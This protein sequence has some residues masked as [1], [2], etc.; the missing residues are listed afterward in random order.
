MSRTTAQLRIG[1]TVATIAIPFGTI[2]AAP[3]ATGGWTIP[4]P[5]PGG[6]IAVAGFNA[7]AKSLAPGIRRA[8]TPYS[9]AERFVP[10]LARRDAGRVSLAASVTDESATRGSAVV[11]LDR[12]L[13]DSVRS[14]RYRLAFTRRSRSSAWTL[15]SAR[16]DQR[17]W[18]GR[19][20]TGF[21][22]A[23]CT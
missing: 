9:L 8:P 15:S 10:G 7:Y 4:T 1:L 21:A 13:D 16:W 20:H 22:P 6:A 3:G 17:C 12:L 18:P 2:P 11:L 19:G 14:T 5:G 23:A